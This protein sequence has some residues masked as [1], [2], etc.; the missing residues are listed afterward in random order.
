L[1]AGI[2]LCLLGHLYRKN[3]C[4]FFSEILLEN[5]TAAIFEN[6]ILDSFFTS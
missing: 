4:G 3:P 6:S 1:L 2:G 5:V